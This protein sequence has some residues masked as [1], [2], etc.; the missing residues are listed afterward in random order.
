MIKLIL[1][2]ALFVC[3]QAQDDALEAFKNKEYE[4]AYKLY[5]VDAE[6]GDSN[7]QS[8]L[9]YLYFNGYGIVK[10]T[11]KGMFWLKKS[12]HNMNA[13]AQYDLAMAYLLGNNAQVDKKLAFTWLDSASDLGNADAQYNLALMYY[14]GDGVEQNV[15]KST[16]LLQSAATQGHKGAIKN[17]GLVYMQN[18]QFDEAIEWLEINANDGDANAYYLL[19]EIY[20]GKEKFVDA[21]K[22]AAKAMEA[23]DVKA[24]ELWKKYDLKSY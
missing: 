17:I 6:N 23:G 2:L 14:Q 20:C 13:R 21:K 15:T 5:V 4:K 7:A 11:D 3:L 9:S 22:W 19:A 12:A 1:T 10:N 8:A 24:G 18:Y 16:Q